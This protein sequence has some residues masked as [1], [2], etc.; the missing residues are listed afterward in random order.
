MIPEIVGEAEL[1][2]RDVKALTKLYR[3]IRA[4]RPH[5]VH[6]HTA[7]ASFLGSPVRIRA[8]RSLR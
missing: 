6:T 5:I 4:R 3:L 8:G 2:G 1:R 7:K